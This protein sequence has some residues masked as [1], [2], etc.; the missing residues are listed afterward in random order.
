MGS[1]RAT[2]YPLWSSRLQTRTGRIVAA[3]LGGQRRARRDADRLGQVAGLSAA[4]AGAAGHDARRLAADL[5]DEGSGR[6]A[7]SA[8]DRG[9]RAAF[10]AVAGR[11]SAR[12]STRR[13]A[14]SFGC[15]MSRPSGSRR[16]V[17]AICWRSRRRAFVV[18]EA[19][20]VSEW[21]HDFRPDY[22]RLAAGAAVPRDGRRTGRPPIAAFTATATPEV[23]DDI[24]ASLAWSVRNCRRRLRPPEHRSA[25]RARRT[26]REGRR[27]PELVGGR[28]ALVY[29]AT[30][31]K[32]ESA[33]AH[34]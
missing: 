24:V 4:G 29:A 28:R 27:L 8:R 7:E 1:D 26:S 30:R 6:R 5:A 31:K 15:S 22:R 12:R 19:H 32:A 33:A 25:R 3:V 34:L 2:S 23:R 9:A 20:C 13:G 14:G 10:D 16:T 18:D 11:R 17:P 21:G